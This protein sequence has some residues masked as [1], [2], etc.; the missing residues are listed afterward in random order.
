MDIQV[1]WAMAALGGLGTMFA[2]VLAYAAQKFAV[3]ADDRAIEITAILPGANCGGCGFAGCAALAS[4]IVDGHADAAACP[5]GGASIAAQ[6][7][8]IMGVETQAL[9]EPTKAYIICNGFDGKTQ[10]VCEYDGTMLCRAANVLAGGSKACRFACLGYGDCYRACKFGAITLNNGKAEIDSDKCR[11]CSACVRACPKSIIKM[12]PDN[13]AVVV[14]CR[15]PDDGRTVR[16]VCTGGCISCRL[17]ERE[18][19]S[20]AIKVIDGLALIDY[21]KCTG[22]GKCAAKCPTN[23]LQTVI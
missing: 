4:A 14:A 13:T 11:R 15:N 9:P 5:V 7:S 3:E 8:A 2:M 23:C 21:D 20:E 18:C 16:G 6:I 17:C 12:Y 1:L 22:C 19:E 10:D